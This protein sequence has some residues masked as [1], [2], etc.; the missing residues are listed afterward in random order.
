MT[1]ALVGY[2]SVFMRYSMAVTPRN[3]LLFGCHAVNF[4]AQ[5]VQVYRYLNYWRYVMSDSNAGPRTS[6]L[7]VKEEKKAG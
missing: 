5:S 3:W 6:C 4:S 1:V 2:S 7:V